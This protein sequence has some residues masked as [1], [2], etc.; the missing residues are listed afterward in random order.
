MTT[1]SG[2]NVPEDGDRPVELDQGPAT[3]ACA[4]CG[5]AVDRS[6]VIDRASV[7]ET[8]RS[9]IEARLG[10]WVGLGRLARAA[11]FGVGAAIVAAPLYATALYYSPVD[12]SPMSVV[13]GYLVGKLVR[14]GSGGRGGLP[15]QVLAV[16]ITYTSL[17]FAYL[18]VDLLDFFATNKDELPLLGQPGFYLVCLKNLFKIPVHRASASPIL[19]VFD[20]FAAWQAWRLNRRRPPSRRR[21]SPGR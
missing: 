21:S 15:C 11:C 2:S 18:A 14:K 17:A 3:I 7:C 12:L 20:G 9:P 10:G 1:G 8:C 13:V 5:R 6:V 4:A 19:L 16:L